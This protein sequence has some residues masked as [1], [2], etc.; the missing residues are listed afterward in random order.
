MSFRSRA[1]QELF[2][3]A[4]SSPTTGSVQ[5]GSIDDA[6]DED[7]DDDDDDNDD[8]DGI[9]G[10]RARLHKQG[11]L[12]RHEIDDITAAIG[13]SEEA[14][15]EEEVQLQRENRPLPELGQLPL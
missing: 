6:G 5:N 15:E 9:E 3:A 4:D 2:P 12:L 11:S 13:D 7:N 8:D 1:L 14:E 10:E